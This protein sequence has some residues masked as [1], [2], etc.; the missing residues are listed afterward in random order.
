MIP[1]PTTDDLALDLEAEYAASD[2]DGV[3]R[4]LI[5]RLAHPPA[6]AVDF[7]RTGVLDAIAVV[8]VRAGFSTLLPAGMIV[9]WREE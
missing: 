3:R 4:A 1:E 5:R 8:S 9:G 2:R 7:N 6:I